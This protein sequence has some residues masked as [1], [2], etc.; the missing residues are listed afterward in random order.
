MKNIKNKKLFYIGKRV[1]PQFSKPYYVAYGQLTKEESH[2]MEDCCYGSM[3]LTSY[4]TENEYNE[5]IDQLIKDGFR[6]S[7]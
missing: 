1:N 3:Y 6:V 7:K 5:S 2:K 4:N